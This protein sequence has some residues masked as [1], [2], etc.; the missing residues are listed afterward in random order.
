MD[1]PDKVCDEAL[2]TYGELTQENPQTSF[3]GA[4]G[5]RNN[6]GILPSDQDQTDN[7]QADKQ[8]KA[9]EPTVLTRGQ[10]AEQDLQ[11][12]LSDVAGTRNN[13]E[14]PHRE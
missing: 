6:L 2:Q 8:Q 1:D 7:Q 13:L 9:Y 12:A 3:P 4:R 11:T 14:D 5:T 10:L